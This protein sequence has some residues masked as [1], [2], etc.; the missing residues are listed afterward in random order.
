MS[1]DCAGIWHTFS[2]LTKKAFR[3]KTPQRWPHHWMALNYTYRYHGTWGRSTRS[4]D[5]TLWQ[6]PYVSS[7]WM[8]QDLNIFMEESDEAF[9]VDPSRTW[10]QDEFS[11]MIIGDH[12]VLLV[13]KL[14]GRRKWANVLLGRWWWW[15]RKHSSVAIE[16][17]RRMQ[18]QHELFGGGAFWR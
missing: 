3:G 10:Q 17:W 8:Q 4:N 11:A 5:Q 18:W 6:D 16:R 2:G 1:L 15:T 14:G 7:C 13:D 12:R 9:P